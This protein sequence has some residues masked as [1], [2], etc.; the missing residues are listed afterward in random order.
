MKELTACNLIS[1]LKLI[2]QWIVLYMMLF[3]YIIYTGASKQKKS[4]IYQL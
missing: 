4:L 2:E 3:W 1:I